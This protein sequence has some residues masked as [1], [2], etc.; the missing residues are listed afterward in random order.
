VTRPCINIGSLL[1]TLR[2]VFTS[3][4][5]LLLLA[6]AARGQWHESAHQRDA[7]ERPRAHSYD[8][9]EAPLRKAAGT[10]THVVHG[11][12]PY[13]I[14]DQAADNYRFELLT[15]L[16]YFSCEID[17]STGA[18]TNTRGWLTSSVPARASAAGVKVLLTVTNFGSAANRSLLGNAAA[19]DTLCAAVLRLLKQRDADGVNIDFESVPAD[20]RDNL[21]LFFSRLRSTL[22]AWREGMVISAATPAVDWSGS[23]DLPSLT[24]FIDLFFIMGYDYHWSGSANAGPVAPLRGWT[25]NVERTVDWYLS[26]GVPPRKL[27]LGVPYYGYDWPVV[28][29]KPMAAATDRA[30]ARIYSVIPDILTHFPRQWSEQ[31]AVPWIP[32]RPAAWRQCWY[33]DEQSLSMKYE[34]VIDRGLGGTGMWALGYDGLLPELWNALERA[35]LRISSV[36]DASHAQHSFELWP[37]PLRAGAAFSLSMQEARD[38]EFTLHDMLG[39]ERY[40]VRTAAGSRLRC[41]ALP[42]GVYIAGVRQGGKVA[43][44]TV[45]IE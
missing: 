11:Y 7:R 39:R 37:L 26:Q 40:R 35:F 41:P 31:Y 9:A 13:W 30:V 6:A 17:A 14:P 22:D 29:D 8:R 44:K 3:A 15:H 43:V 33:D 21:T 2:R 28:D 42:G 16:A 32:Y 12:H 4:G 19:R 23:W 38:V 25:L 20:Q 24:A 18:P 1:K 34:L 10:L 45:V 36:R 27:L 5:L